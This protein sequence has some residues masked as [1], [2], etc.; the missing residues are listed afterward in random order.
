[1]CNTT[2]GRLNI[3]PSG[4]VNVQAEGLFSNAACFTSLDGASFAVDANG[5][6][7]IALANGWL[8][9]PFGTSVAA[10]RNDSR[11]IQFRGAVSGGTNTVIGTLPIGFRPATTVWVNV[12]LCQA[13]KGRLVVSPNGTVQVETK[14]PFADAQC[15]TSL[16][17]ASFV[18]D[19]AVDTD[20]DRL[21]NIWETNT[22]VYV[23]ADN[24]GTNPNVADTDGDGVNDGDEVLTTAGGLNLR[25]M[26]A[27]PLHKNLFME[28]DWFNDSNDGCGAHS[29]RP[30][31]T[32]IGA[33]HTA[34]RNAPVSNPDG[35]PG[36][37]V[38]SDY[39]QG[40]PFLG[41]NAIADA[42]GVVAGRTEGT[43]FVNYK[44]A[45]FAASRNGYFHYVLLPHRYDSTSP[46]SGVAEINGD[47]FIVSL[48]CSVTNTAT[49]ANTIMH[50]LGH[51]LGLR[52]GGN[53][54]TN[55]KPNYNSVMN[56]RF[57]FPGIDADC[58]ALGDGVLNYSVGTR[59]ALDES[60]LNE[61]LGVCGTRSID[62]NG[63]FFIGG[64]VVDLNSDGSM[65]VL[66]DFNDWA[67]VNFGGISDGSGA[68]VRQE[69]VE[70][71]P[72]PAA[73]R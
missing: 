35:V 42:D 43:D 63:N 24:T 68:P 26:G 1:M 25:N 66:N 39:G 21:A 19:A 37:Q 56:Y 52:H 71:Q 69:I 41:G 17:G 46:S 50:E 67:G 22:N 14:R 65:D 16:D 29:H 27:S 59:I 73:Y 51:N 36:I 44:A 8:S 9:S 15:F 55:G 61:H 45:N 10:V 18:V 58:D 31:A 6:T 32:Q 34:F 70:E 12:D 20:G 54:D 48:Q 3:A 7:N 2:K 57:Q 64:A 60:N 13:H 23:N 11:I 40:G 62:W 30:T 4:V 49:V 53:V 28:F 72:V 47:D 5:F 33:F 38:I